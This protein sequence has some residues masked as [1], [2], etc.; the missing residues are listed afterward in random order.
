MPINKI[1]RTRTRYFRH[2]YPTY[3]W[4]YLFRAQVNNNNNNN[5]S[6]LIGDPVLCCYLKTSLMNLLLAGPIQLP[7]AIPGPWAFWL[8]RGTCQP[9]F[10]LPESCP[11]LGSRAC[12]RP[13][14]F[15]HRVRQVSMLLTYK[16]AV[17]LHIVSYVY[18]K[19]LGVWHNVKDSISHFI[20]VNLT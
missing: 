6:E 9:E 15:P 4:Q 18:L 10:R 7:S 1:T 16:N 17:S 8:P 2:A 12:Y 3:T 13:R 19:Y 5:S 14:G 11:S 20:I